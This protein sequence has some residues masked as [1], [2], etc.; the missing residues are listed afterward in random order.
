MAYPLRR[1]TGAQISISAMLGA[2]T[3]VAL[4][5]DTHAEQKKSAVAP[6]ELSQPASARPWVRYN[7]WPATDLKAY[8]TLAKTA[9]PPIRHRPN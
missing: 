8:N 7:G 4:P 9:S 1:T 2:M 5:I 3:F 6:M